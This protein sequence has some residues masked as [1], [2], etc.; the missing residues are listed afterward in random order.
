VTSSAA[1]AQRQF[2]LIGIEG[3]GMG[4]VGII[5]KF[6]GADI[7]GCD[8][9][10][11]PEHHEA[12]LD[13]GIPVALGHDVSHLA[14]GATLVRSYVVPDD[15]PEVAEAR[16]RS[17]LW[18]RTDLLAS[19]FAERQGVGITGSHGKGTVT[20]LTGAALEAAG[21][22]PLVL[23][24]SEVPYFGGS[25]RLGS[26]PLVAEVDDSD[27]SLAKVT[28]EVAVVTNLDEDHPHLRIPL[29]RAVQGV[30]EFVARATRR[31]ILGP[32]PRAS[33]L[34]AYAQTEVWQYGV[35]FGA[36]IESQANGCTTLTLW[37]P[38]VPPTQARLRLLIARAEVNAA[39]AFAVAI[40]LGANAALAAAGLE[41]IDRILRRLEP[42]PSASGVRVF[43]DFGGK[44]P[45]NVRAGLATL[46]RH[47][48]HAQ[49]TA[50]FEAYGPYLPRWG[51]RY[52]RAL[53]GADR[54][55]N[56]PP[57]FLADYPSN[58]V[59]DPT[60][61]SPCRVPLVQARDQADAVALAMANSRPGDVVVFFVQANKSRVMAHNAAQRGG[62]P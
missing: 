53:S 34:R 31:V 44:H 25:T 30:G 17:A 35:D 27:L 49:I 26:G 52:A 3:R 41:R 8:R 51:R 42:I 21:I 59:I 48:P 61:V 54:V 60:W 10:V 55:V 19:V 43:D 37:A 33:Q 15:N 32:S 1:L 50:V 57:I 47:Y 7:S 5:A 46:R 13:A 11:W 45:A 58:I 39:L 29:S 22:D 24:G 36:R 12:L 56:V 38:G 9:T 40:T 23:L 16:R 28:C 6:L 2:H 4:P 18:D 14:P 62:T 20:A